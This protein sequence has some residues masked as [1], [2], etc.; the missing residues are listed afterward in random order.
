MESS[1]GA[2]RKSITQQLCNAEAQCNAVIGAIK[3][4]NTRLRS[5]LLEATRPQACNKKHEKPPE[6]GIVQM[7]HSRPLSQHRVPSLSVQPFSPLDPGQ[8]DVCLP[9]LPET[10]T[11]EVLAS[12]PSLA[13]PNNKA[14]IYMPLQMA[15]IVELKEEQNHN[16]EQV[17]VYASEASID[18]T[19]A[20]SD[21]AAELTLHQVSEVFSVE[22]KEQSRETV[23]G[24]WALLYTGITT[25]KRRCRPITM[26]QSHL[27]L[28]SFWSL[29]RSHV[30]SRRVSLSATS[31]TLRSILNASIH[32][33]E[34]STDDCD[35]VGSA[36]RSEN[37]WL[38]KLTIHPD[39]TVGILHA[40]LQGLLVL[41]DVIYFPLSAFYSDEIAFSR[42][43]TIISLVFW[44]LDMPFNF[45]RGYQSPDG[46]I[47]MRPSR[48][49]RHYL[50]T[51]FFFDITIFSSELLLVVFHSASQES[52]LA[53][54][55]KLS[56][57]AR[58]IRGGRLIRLL[59][60]VEKLNHW[61]H[62]TP[63]EEVTVI[64]L[65]ILGLI[66]LILLINH[67]VAC[68]WYGITEL[69]STGERQEESW[70]QVQQLEGSDVF[71][72]YWTSLHWS[73]TQFAPCTNNIAPANS[74][75]RFFACFVVLFAL[76]VFSTFVS[77]LTSATMQMKKVNFQR[78]HEESQLREFM[79]QKHLPLNVAGRVWR[80][81]R[82]HYRLRNRIVREAD[83]PIFQAMPVRLRSEVRSHAYVP[84]LKTHPVID[85]LVEEGHTSRL[86]V[87]TLDTLLPVVGHDIF[88]EGELA[89]NM[90]YVVN[91]VAIYQTL[92]K[93]ETQICPED[94]ISEAALWL[95]N[96]VHL[97]RFT[98][99]D[100]RSEMLVLDAGKFIVCVESGA[101]PE[102]T[103]MLRKYASMFTT[104]MEDGMALQEQE[105][106]ESNGPVDH[107]GFLLYSDLPT[108]AGAREFL[109]QKSFAYLAKGSGSHID[110]DKHGSDG[111]KIKDALKQGVRF[112]AHAFRARLVH[113]A[114][115]MSNTSGVSSNS[116][117]S[118]GPKKSLE[119]ESSAR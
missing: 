42:V 81:Y 96:W 38:Q 23:E 47:E 97:G 31:G 2:L 48:V 24:R 63:S 107:A 105:Y 78:Y 22:G 39:H 21:E 80:Y 72:L 30:R 64:Y 94:I 41:C 117:T 7:L 102:M 58:L 95:S 74:R 85:K 65:R 11:A 73:L 113:S 88:V 1:F 51:W 6:N 16:A 55:L 79:G 33:V 104:Y 119:S 67:Y 54:V 84:T 76:L 82:K 40:L 12:P 116:N 45:F 110:F 46:V 106:G 112:A 69:M 36:K 103:R 56:K 99:G 8:F 77:S 101:S 5:Q 35:R 15:A 70:V 59:K 26:R 71:D 53:R 115:S 20:D 9:K 27:S 3:L 32:C 43:T 29:A 25:H 91:G 10:L 49:G 86:L 28:R 109:V 52:R 111:V 60:S 114:S 100:K 98:A 50:R 18:V 44:G 61:I 62:D 19:G 118:G 13:I 92:G 89:S 83:V 66:L 87:D 14:S 17:S 90:Y 68:A 57:V 4:E 108:E 34:V 75:E 37:S 93:M